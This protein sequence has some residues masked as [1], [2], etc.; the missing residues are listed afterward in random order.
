MY[1]SEIA[2]L[3]SREEYHD[4][5]ETARSFRSWH[6]CME[7]KTCKI[8]ASVGITIALLLAIGL[9]FAC[10]RGCR[11]SLSFGEAFCCCCVKRRKYEELQTLQYPPPPPPPEKPIQDPLMY[12]TKPP[13]T[14]IYV[15]SAPPAYHA[16]EAIEGSSR[17]YLASSDDKHPF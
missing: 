14:H 16:S 12:P 6:T 1:T 9:F 15:P 11:Y 2:Y 8:T 4:G 5:T 10:V 7:N 17:G 13:M 3:V